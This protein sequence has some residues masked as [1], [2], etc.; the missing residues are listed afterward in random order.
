[1]LGLLN[2]SYYIPNV[3]GQTAF[4][5]RR[6]RRRRSLFAIV[7]ARGA[8]PNEMGP[9]HCRRR[10]SLLP[11]VSGEASLQEARSPFWFQVLA[12]RYCAG[13]SPL[14]NRATRVCEF[15]DPNRQDSSSPSSHTPTLHARMWGGIGR[16][17][18]EHSDHTVLTGA[19]HRGRCIDYS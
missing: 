12:R 10:R 19:A 5:R 11:A 6:R 17:I 13:G 8:I 15:Y 1:M 9:T 2:E 7:H 14:R 4:R 18:I 3:V 16:V